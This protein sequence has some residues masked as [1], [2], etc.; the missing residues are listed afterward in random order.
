MSC[1]QLPCALVDRSGTLFQTSAMKSA[2]YC[3]CD[4][5]LPRM[6]IN[7]TTWAFNGAWAALV[8][9]LLSRLL[10]TESREADLEVTC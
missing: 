2:L 5:F 1:F 9:T 6:F 8:N 10:E 4:R 3:T 7:S